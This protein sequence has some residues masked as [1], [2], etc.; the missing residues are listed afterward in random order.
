[1]TKKEFT[2]YCKER[3]VEASYDGK[4][5]TFFLSGMDIAVDSII[6]YFRHQILKFKLRKK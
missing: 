4:S 1:M 2:K 3:G 6:S 5:K